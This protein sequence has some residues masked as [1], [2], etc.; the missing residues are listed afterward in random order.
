MSKNLLGID[1]NV[2]KDFLEEAVKQTVIVGIAESLNGKNEIVSQI[3]KSVLNVKVDDRGRISNYER[4]NKYSLIEY[5]V[6]QL[7]EE[8]AKEA[9]IESMNES[10]DA[11][12]AMI[13]KEI[14]SKNFQS[15]VVSDILNGMIENL[16]NSYRTT[17]NVTLDK[18]EKY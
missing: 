18:K 6:R 17:V 16:T 7:I 5:Y 4:E 15:N 14:L 11:I 12:K 3:V 8:Q 13:K 10:K 2:D 9:I 1:L